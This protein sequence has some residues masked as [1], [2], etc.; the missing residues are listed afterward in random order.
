MSDERAKTHVK[1]IESALDR[2]TK[3]RG[4]S[5]SLKGE[6]RQGGPARLGLIAQEVQKVVPEAV[7]SREEGAGIS[8]STFVPLL[9]EAVK[10]LKDQ[11]AAL[12][13]E[14]KALSTAA[15]PPRA[16]ATKKK[17]KP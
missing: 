2:V 1:G 11:V 9:V 17:A 10:E 4:V 7:T 6:E 13:R 3:L 8:Y 16:R 14:V 12:Q 5:Y 15:R